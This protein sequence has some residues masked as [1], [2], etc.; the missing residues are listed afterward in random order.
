MGWG[1]GVL[2]FREVSTGGRDGWRQKLGGCG[3][4]MFTL[5]TKRVQEA[6]RNQV[7]KVMRVNTG[8]KVTK[9]GRS[10]KG[11][12]GKGSRGM[13]GWIEEGGEERKGTGKTGVEGLSL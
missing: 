9:W 7:M 3:R 2:S 10:G 11:G 4:F 12:G 1:R 8:A 13:E 5:Y 6:K